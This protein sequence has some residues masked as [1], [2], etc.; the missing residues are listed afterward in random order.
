[1]Q[2]NYKQPLFRCNAQCLSLIETFSISRRT[3]HHIATACITSTTCIE[4][5]RAYATKSITKTVPFLS[6]FHVL[7]QY[8]HLVCPLG[9]YAYSKGQVPRQDDETQAGLRV[10][11]NNWVSTHPSNGACVLCLFKD[12]RRRQMRNRGGVLQSRAA[13][14]PG[15]S[16][17]QFPG[18]FSPHLG[19][20]A[21]RTRLRM[22][23]HR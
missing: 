1:M 8:T 2:S 23:K 13:G 20:F 16:G 6:V 12:V 11:S 5:C 14:Y 15:E 7:L 18:T 22:K 3:L 19:D 4:K 17:K 21:K 9:A 10:K